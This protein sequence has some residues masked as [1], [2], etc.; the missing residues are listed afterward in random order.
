M[1]TIAELCRN[2]NLE[3]IIEGV[4]SKEQYQLLEQMGYHLIQGYYFSKPVSV[5][6]LPDLLAADMIE[7]ELPKVVNA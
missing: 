3:C 5:L 1:S 4:E 7:D 6:E 2:L